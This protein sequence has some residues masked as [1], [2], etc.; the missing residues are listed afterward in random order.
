MRRDH[1]VGLSVQTRRESRRHP[2]QSARR[3]QSASEGRYLMLA[4]ARLPAIEALHSI[5]HDYMS[6]T[7]ET[8]GRPTGDPSHVIR[9]AQLVLDRTGMH[10]TL[11]VQA[12][13]AVRPTTYVG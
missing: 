7:R 1:D 12:T 11:A 13:Q 8:C 9:T 3:G 5:I 2:L 10:P 6:D 4:R